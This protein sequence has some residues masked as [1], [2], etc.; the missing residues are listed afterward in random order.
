MSTVVTCD[1]EDYHDV[2]ADSCI[3]VRRVS[4]SQSQSQNSQNRSAVSQSESQ[5]SASN[6]S[7]STQPQS[8]HSDCESQSQSIDGASAAESFQ[9]WLDGIPAGIRNSVETM[10]NQLKEIHG[11]DDED[12]FANTKASYE[13]YHPRLVQR[14]MHAF[15]LSDYLRRHQ[16]FILNN[17]SHRSS[18]QKLIESSRF[19]GDPGVTFTVIAMDRPKL[20]EDSGEMVMVKSFYGSYP[21]SI[22]E[23]LLMTAYYFP[24]KGPCY[25]EVIDA[26]KEYPFFV[27]IEIKRQDDWSSERFVNTFGVTVEEVVLTELKC[28]CG[29]ENFD[30][31]DDY[32]K[33][34]VRAMCRKY[35]ELSSTEWTEAVCRAGYQVMNSYLS[36]F[37]A[38]TTGKASMKEFYTT[39][40][41]RSDKFSIHMVS[42]KV[43]CDSSNASMRVLAWEAARLFRQEN[44]LEVFNKCQ[45]GID[46]T[47]DPELEFNIRALMLERTIKKPRT[48][49]RDSGKIYFAADDDTPMDENMYRSSSHLLRGPYSCK[50]T[51]ARALVPVHD[52]NLN[53]MGAAPGLTSESHD[54]PTTLPGHITDFPRSVVASSPS[55][56]S[57]DTFRKYTVTMRQ[58]AEDLTPRTR[59]LFNQVPCSDDFPSPSSYSANLLRLKEIQ[60]GR[61]SLYDVLN[62]MN[63]QAYKEYRPVQNMS[64]NNG[65]DRRTNYRSFHSEPEGFEDAEIISPMHP[66]YTE[67]EGIDTPC[68]L[69]TLDNKEMCY[70]DHGRGVLEKTPSMQ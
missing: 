41:C 52:D 45:G 44:L 18:K 56:V 49:D 11:H 35:F 69:Y 61:H 7:Y 37:M 23:A 25:D 54:T 66:V 33:D 4:Q 30:V 70:C 8:N 32:N 68:S 53:L 59:V 16:L 46:G 19:Y 36:N 50:A 17:F 51:G 10:Y 47:V 1:L 5:V 55:T 40:G 2:I 48:R 13:K 31:D 12:A 63:H 27:D 58:N 6:Q 14:E 28:L 9:R 39:T 26:G 21:S 42:D 64:V 24:E 29:E 20:R 62:T 34:T 60:R 15:A 65:G 67:R 57:F 3:R 22:Y 38:L 43:Y